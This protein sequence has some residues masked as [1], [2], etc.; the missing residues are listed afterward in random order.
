MNETI[1]KHMTPERWLWL[2]GTFIYLVCFVLMIYAPM[3]AETA[4]ISLSLG[5]PAL[6]AVVTFIY[7]PSDKLKAALIAFVVTGTVILALAVTGYGGIIVEL[8]VRLASII[9]LLACLVF[10]GT[11]LTFAYMHARKKGWT[12]QAEKA[13]DSSVTKFFDQFKEN[14]N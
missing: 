5:L 6:G 9:Q 11:P 13:V 4:T 10:V 12:T 3:I 8:F 2:I 7:A 1:K 14:K